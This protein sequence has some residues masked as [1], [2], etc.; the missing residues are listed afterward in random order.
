M[1]ATSHKARFLYSYFFL[2]LFFPAIFDKY[3]VLTIQNK[4]FFFAWWRISYCL[5]Y[6]TSKIIFLPE[7]LSEKYKYQE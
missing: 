7:M 5:E 3:T 1:N 6:I 2:I 4:D